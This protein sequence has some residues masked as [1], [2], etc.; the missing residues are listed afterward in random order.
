MRYPHPTP[1]SPEFHRMRQ[2]AAIELA[3][4]A[5][6]QYREKRAFYDAYSANAA[7]AQGEVVELQDEVN[8]MILLPDEPTL[9]PVARQ[10]AIKLRELVERQ[11]LEYAAFL[12]AYEAKLLE[13]GCPEGELPQERAAM[14]EQAFP[15]H[16][17]ESFAPGEDV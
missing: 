4:L 15:G 5:D 8:A 7:D 9:H 12:E 3:E 16:W 1:E 2:R 11:R 10:A 13:S 14:E 6:R 17:T